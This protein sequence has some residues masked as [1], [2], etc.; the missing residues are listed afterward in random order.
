ME[1]LRHIAVMYILYLN[2]LRIVSAR[3]YKDL[4][5]NVYENSTK[6]IKLGYCS[7]AKGLWYLDQWQ[8]H[9]T[10]IQKVLHGLNPNW[11][12]IFWNFFA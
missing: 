7:S 2:F 3:L 10:C 5:Y 12:P 9:L 8:E 4:H 6:C 11:V 1:Q